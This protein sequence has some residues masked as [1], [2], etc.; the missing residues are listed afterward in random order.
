[1]NV[2]K[3]RYGCLTNSYL[4]IWPKIV[5]CSIWNKKPLLTKKSLFKML[6]SLHRTAKIEYTST[7]GGCQHI[8][9]WDQ[10]ALT[11][12]VLAPHR[13]PL[14]VISLQQISRLLMCSVLCVWRF[15]TAKLC[16]GEGST[17][18]IS[19]A[20]ATPISTVRHK[21]LELLSVIAGRLRCVC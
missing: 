21:S 1:M 20:N 10:S 6:R 17:I 12:L 11:V 3:H 16:L 2:A 18:T 8:F 5:I 13:G 4:F 7:N 9:H 14:A 19:G 15:F